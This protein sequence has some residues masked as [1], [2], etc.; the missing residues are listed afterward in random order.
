MMRQCCHDTCRFFMGNS[1]R[2]APQNFTRAKHSL[3]I[4]RLGQV[5]GV[6]FL[7]VKHGAIE[8]AV[9]KETILRYRR[10]V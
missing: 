5:Q 2:S 1:A 8:Q 6:V 9:N 7:C 10:T 3:E 4:S